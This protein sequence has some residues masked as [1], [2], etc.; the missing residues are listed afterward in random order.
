VE[1]GTAKFQARATVVEGEER[2]RL[3]AQHAAAMPEFA[4]YAKLTT[5]QIPVILLDRVA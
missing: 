4:E 1:L 2:K 5:R 3:Y